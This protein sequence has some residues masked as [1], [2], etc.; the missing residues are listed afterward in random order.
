VSDLSDDL[1]RWDDP[2]YVVAQ[3]RERLGYVFP[4]ETPYRVVDPEVVAT[5]P[6]D[7]S[8]AIETPVTTVL[9]PWYST[10]WDSIEQAGNPS[11]DDAT[12]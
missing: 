3:A 7:V 11:Q 9:A 12:P 1:A 10:L 8:G 6:N 2:A 4:G 5:E